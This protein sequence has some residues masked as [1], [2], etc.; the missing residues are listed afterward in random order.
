MTAHRLSR[1]EFIKAAQLLFERGGASAITMRA[2]GKELGVDPTA[3]YRHF[4]NKDSIIMAL[5]F[6][7]VEEQFR[8]LKISEDPEQRILKAG[9]L[10][11]SVLMSYPEL[12]LALMTATEA[13]S[14]PL[15][16]EIFI[17]SAIRELG[18]EGDELVR[19]YQA[20]ESFVMGAVLFDSGSA[21][22]NWEIRRQ[23]YV[24]VGDPAFVK[25]GRS[26][27]SVERNTE[28]A[29]EA[30]YKNL[31]RAITRHELLVS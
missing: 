9:L 15:E 3:A 22:R 13:P 30:A 21:P 12:A 29:F 11:R 19:C 20:I 17:S 1:D 16:I 18:Y 14:G 4:E 24:N 8:E 5:L 23:R 10:V 2:L 27:A 6:S 7:F 26:E 28:A 31:V 25:V